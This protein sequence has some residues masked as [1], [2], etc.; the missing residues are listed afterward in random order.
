MMSGLFMPLATIACWR[1]SSGWRRYSIYKLE[2]LD[3]EMV[4]L[5]RHK[6]IFDYLEAE[7]IKQGRLKKAERELSMVAQNVIELG[8]RLKQYSEDITSRF[9]MIISF[10]SEFQHYKQIIERQLEVNSVET[11]VYS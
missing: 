11:K 10:T 5:N 6:H 8:T 2:V 3:R 4:R 7:M 1:T 9:N